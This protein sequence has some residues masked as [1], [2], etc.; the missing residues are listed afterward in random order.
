MEGKI[1]VRL[2]PAV[3]EEEVSKWRLTIGCNLEG[4][5]TLHWGVS[6][7]DDLGRQALCFFSVAPICSLLLSFWRADLLFYRK[8]HKGFLFVPFVPCLSQKAK[9]TNKS[10]FT[11]GSV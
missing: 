8:E 1:T 11:Y 2:D 9:K 7:C 6:Y 4:K 5:W 10:N 3:A